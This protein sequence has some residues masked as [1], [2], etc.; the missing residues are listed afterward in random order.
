[1]KKLTL[2]LILLTTAVVAQAQITITDAWV[3]G[4]VPMQQASGAFM[5]LSADKDTR[6]VAAKSPVANVVEI[7]EMVM[8]NNIMKMRQIPGLDIVPGRVLE[9]KPGGY[10]VMLIELKQQ[11]KGGDVVPIT[12]VFEDTATKKQFTQEVQAPVTALGAG[13]MPMKH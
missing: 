7:H 9:L 2:S 6:L 11:L 10:H 8:D 4:T 5:Q 13:N 12:L 1:M 3:R